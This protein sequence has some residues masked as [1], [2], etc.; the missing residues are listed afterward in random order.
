MSAQYTQKYPAI[1]IAQ[2]GND[3]LSTSGDKVQDIADANDAHYIYVPSDLILQKVY[4]ILHLQSRQGQLISPIYDLPEEPAKLIIPFLSSVA[5][6][7]TAW[8]IQNFNDTIGIVVDSTHTYHQS[9]SFEQEE[10]SNQITQGGVELIVNFG[11]DG[12]DNIRIKGL[13]LKKVRKWAE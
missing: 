9:F 11:T 4:V 12:L 5:P 1:A 2:Q 13:E 3:W 10:V 8:T 7:G 6:D